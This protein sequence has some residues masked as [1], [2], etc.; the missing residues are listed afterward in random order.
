MPLT[1][2]GVI[3]EAY[4]LIKLVLAKDPLSLKKLEKMNVFLK[5]RGFQNKALW[6]IPFPHKIS[7]LGYLRG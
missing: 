2:H 6:V 5:F 1:I 4:F 3:V 7:I